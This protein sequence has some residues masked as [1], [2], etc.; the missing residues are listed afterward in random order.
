PTSFPTR[1]SSDLRSDPRGAERERTPVRSAHRLGAA[2]ALRASRGERRRSDDGQGAGMVFLDVV[3]VALLT[4]KLAG[5]SL[6]TLADIP[7][8]GTRLAFAAIA[9]QV[10][11]F[12][13]GVLPW[14]MPSAAARVLWLVS[15]ALLLAM[16]LRNRRLF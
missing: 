4:G 2:R 16:L 7:I 10:V 5:G 9:L 1:R 6:G 13:S 3:V 12:P 14:G 8:R 15:Y 11:A